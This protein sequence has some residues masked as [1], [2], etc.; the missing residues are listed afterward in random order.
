MWGGGVGDGGAVHDK[1]S[2]KRTGKQI[3]A[4]FLQVQFWAVE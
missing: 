2:S 4:F 1:N 3:A